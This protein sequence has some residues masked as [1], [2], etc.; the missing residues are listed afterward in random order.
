MTSPSPGQLPAQDA[1]QR[2]AGLLDAVMCVT[3]DLDLLTVLST[4]V[5]TACRLSGAQYGALGVLGPQRDRLVQFVT[6]GIDDEV[7]DRIG[8]LP[9]GHGVLGLLLGEDPRPIRLRDI[10]EHPASV[11]FPVNHP[12]MRSF[13]GVPVRTREAVF[14]NLYLT[15]KRDAAAEPCA[16]TEQDQEVVMALSAAAGV[17][18]ENAQLYEHSRLREAWLE[19]AG[20]SSQQLASYGPTPAV[21]AHVASAA[22]AASTADVALLALTDAAPFGPADRFHPEVREHSMGL[23]CAASSGEVSTPDASQI[24]V[25]D[26]FGSDPI[27]RSPVRCSPD[28][29]ATVG[30]SC[31]H[32]GLAAPMWFGDTLMG[33]LVL[34][35]RT[36]PPPAGDAV[37]PLAVFAERV[38]MA[39]EAASVQAYRAR[40]AVLEDRDRIA[41]DLHDLVIQRLFA[42]GLSLQTAEADAGRPESAQRLHRAVDDLDDTIKDVRRTIFALHS[43]AGHD[44]RNQL[45]D[46]VAEARASLGFVPRLL[47]EGP[48]IAVPP[49][50]AADVVA[51]VRELLSNVVRHSGASHVEVRLRIGGDVEV[52]VGD[53]GAGIDPAVR[54]RSGLANLAERASAHGGG[55]EVSDRLPHGTTVTWSVPLPSGR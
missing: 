24:T 23:R 46:V 34:G 15:Q 21:L 1:Q 10:A 16:F 12:P 26:L 18:I 45:D 22:R 38:A 40:L 37:A 3:A 19:A 55:I 50:V 25:D 2:L 9:T 35:W 29:L 30:L 27:A 44:L 48:S 20:S 47:I 17:A 49:E 36:Q 41:R 5:R 33:A 28:L 14:G 4:I 39:L 51:V 8:H 43:P 31:W 54:R 6:H 7:R 32:G 53:D 13:L 11:G 52:H 42:V